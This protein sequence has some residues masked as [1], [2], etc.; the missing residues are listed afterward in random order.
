MHSSPV[1][2]LLAIRCLSVV[3]GELWADD[4]GLG[5]RN[6]ALPRCAPHSP[7]ELITAAIS[8]RPPHR[9]H[10]HVGAVHS[11]VPERVGHVRGPKD[12]LSGPPVASA[13]PIDASAGN[14]GWS[15]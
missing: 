9:A 13:R 12:V 4:D 1:N 11:D 6:S 15:R 10:P 14:T 3:L 8:T 5:Y 7:T 2:P